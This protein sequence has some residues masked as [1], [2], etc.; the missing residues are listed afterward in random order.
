M[1]VGI[2]RKSSG[3]IQQHLSSGGVLIQALAAPIADCYEAEQKI[4]EA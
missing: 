2:G 3:R 1:K 4:I